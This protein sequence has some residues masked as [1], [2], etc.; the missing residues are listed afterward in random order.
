MAIE[1]VQEPVAAL[2]AYA[3][4]GCSFLVDRLAYAAPR[5]DGTSALD[6]R[7]RLI[8]APYIKDYDADDGGGPL[9][10]PARFDVSR[11]VL[12]GAH[13]AGRRVGGAALALDTPELAGGRGD[14]AVLWDLRVDPVARGR[15]VGSALF[16]AAEAAARSR[17]CRELMAETQNV[18]VPA[19]RFYARHGC[20]IRTANPLAYPDLPGEVQMLW[21]KDLYA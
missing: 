2:A 14:L 7:E 15:G 8:P 4:V 21:Y 17:G 10:W 5:R 9:S 16:H 19:C 13:A 11:W 12:L 20:V 1:I 6:L 3:A 18:N